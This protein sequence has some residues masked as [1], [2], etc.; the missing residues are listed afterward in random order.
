MNGC[1]NMSGNHE[2]GMFKQLEEALHK[3]DELGDKVN[4]IEAETTNKYLQVI[5]EKDLEI[6]RLRAENA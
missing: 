3:I 5:Y 1:G 4:R 2:R 6:A